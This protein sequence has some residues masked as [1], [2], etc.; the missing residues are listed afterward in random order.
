MVKDAYYFLI[1][2]GILALGAA[3]AGVAIL[4][5]IFILLAGFV[6]VFFRD[7]ERTIPADPNA[8]VSPADGKIIQL[9]SDE[10]GTT[11]SI[12]LSIFDVHV[13]RAPVGGVI[14]RQEYCPGRFVAAFDERA[15]IENERMIVTIGGTR[16]LTFS[17]VAGLIARR[18]VA[19]KNKGDRLSKGDKIALIRFG[20]RVDIL[21]PPDCEVAVKKGD[22]VQGGSSVIGYWSV[23][24]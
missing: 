16:E 11:L 10:K 1:P 21:L 8:V 7:P 19:W 5:T 9:R 22:R 20:S 17:L 14:L 3:Y 6:A 13:N 15:S 23:G 24:S 18:I 4:A 12:F 2:L